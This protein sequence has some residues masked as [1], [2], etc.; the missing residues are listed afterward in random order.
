MW[1]GRRGHTIKVAEGRAV[2]AVVMAWA[3]LRKWQ[4]L[5]ENGDERPAVLP[6]LKD[7]SCNPILMAIPLPGPSFCFLMC[8]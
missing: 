5:R 4:E 6:V 2:E 7:T 1:V 8:Q 3:G